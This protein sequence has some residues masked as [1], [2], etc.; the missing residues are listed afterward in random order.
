[1]AEC[2]T[3]HHITSFCANSTYIYA[4]PVTVHPNQTR[5]VHRTLVPSPMHSS[6]LLSMRLAIHP[7]IGR[8]IS[9]DLAP[10]NLR[11]NWPF[12]TTGE[13]N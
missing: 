3:P 12:A 9:L 13:T 2:N 1:M 4:F 5:L 11:S 8:P 7:I 6:D 10:S